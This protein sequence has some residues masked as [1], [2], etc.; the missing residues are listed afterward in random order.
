[1]C[2]AHPKVQGAH[3]KA[4]IKSYNIKMYQKVQGHIFTHEKVLDG[5][6][7]WVPVTWFCFVFGHYS[8]YSNVLLYGPP[9]LP[10]ISI[11][12]MS[13]Y[14]YHPIREQFCHKTH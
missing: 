8:T 7:R 4:S 13:E 11:T 5:A 9:K 2:N 3:E 10:L 6:C 1:M 12:S 14:D